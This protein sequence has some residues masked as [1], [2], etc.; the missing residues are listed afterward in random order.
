MDSIFIKVFNDSNSIKFLMKK[1]PSLWWL[2]VCHS[3]AMLHYG[4]VLGTS[5][6]KALCTIV[7]NY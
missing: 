7:I 4:G 1:Q 6:V 3:G 2:A 5:D